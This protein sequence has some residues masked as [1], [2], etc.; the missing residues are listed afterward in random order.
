MRVESKL[1]T[2]RLP[3]HANFT[4][5]NHLGANLLHKP[6]VLD[7]VMN[8]V[9]T[10]QM[11]S[12]NP[13]FSALS[14]VKGGIDRIGSTEWE[15]KLRGASTRPLVVIE[16][17]EPASNVTLG[18]YGQTFK[19]KLDENWFKAGDVLTPGN[20]AYQVRI[21]TN[22][23]SHGKGWI[24][25]VRLMTDNQSTF[26][27]LRYVK[28]NQQWSKLYSLYEEGGEQSG[29]TQY[30]MPF[31]LKSR[32]SRLRKEY[33]VTGDATT[34][35]LAM[36]IPDSKGN[37]H[38][39]WIKYAEAEYW[40]QWYREKERLLWYGK[41]SDTVLGENGRP[42]FSGP[43]IQELMSDGHTHTYSVMTAKLI[44]EFL[45]DVF[46]NRVAP[47]SQRHIK[48]WTGEYGMI[49]F[50]RAVSDW[51]EKRGFIQVVDNTFIQKGS[52]NYHEN[53]LSAGYQYTKY[54]MANGSTLE[55]IH[56]PLYDDRQIN[57][58]IDPITGYPI[59]SQ[60]ITFLDF[61]NGS[62]GQ[63]VKIKAKKGGMSLGYVSGLVTPYGP[64]NGKMMA[65]QGDYYTMAVKD[66][67][68]VHIEDVT[69]CGEL[70]LGRNY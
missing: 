17:V 59:E 4:E 41:S 47:G 30:S 49:Q 9:F 37:M 69:K 35:V 12:D 1:V 61:S 5:S 14:K 6:E 24:Y 18:K 57:F 13:L 54:R 16:N 62:G 68:G 26:L 25:E 42:I 10:A 58:E 28:T 32:M 2:Q 50:H 29:S 43:G 15:W 38:P 40:Q 8:Q 55:L 63:N 34:D 48:G 39:T 31:M 7:G 46:Y 19:L 20:N 45:M 66:Q 52:S 11:Y 3:W 60:R 36:K 56:N 44:E 67:F 53:S 27:P 33:S 64:A 65:H 23:Y 21:A 22:P 51:M 70:I